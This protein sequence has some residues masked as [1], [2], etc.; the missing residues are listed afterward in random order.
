MI[1]PLGCIILF[2]MNPR[3]WPSKKPFRLTLLGIHLD[4]LIQD[5]EEIDMNQLFTILDCNRNHLKLENK[6][7]WY[8]EKLMLKQLEKGIKKCKQTLTV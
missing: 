2:P 7:V 3:T 5:L 8:Q 1:N 4:W 6:V